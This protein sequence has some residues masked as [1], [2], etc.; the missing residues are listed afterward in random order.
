MAEKKSMKQLVQNEEWQ[1]VRKSLLGMWKSNPE[2]CC[3]QLRN[4]LGP[5]NHT[6]NR[7]LKIMLNY[8]NCVG[9]KKII[10]PGKNIFTKEV[11]LQIAKRK[12]NYGWI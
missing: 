3:Q 1:N 4:Y 9:L 12:K 7:K 11:S 8:L 2:Y 6:E 5:I 10:H